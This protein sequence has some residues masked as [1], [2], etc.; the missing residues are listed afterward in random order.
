MVT[1]ACDW[2]LSSRIRTVPGEGAHT[3]S[4]LPGGFDSGR[5]IGVFLLTVEETKTERRLVAIFPFVLLSR[6]AARCSLQASSPSINIGTVNTHTVLQPR[7]NNTAITCAKKPSW[8]GR[9]SIRRCHQQQTHTHTH[10]FTCTKAYFFPAF[11]NFSIQ[12]HRSF[13]WDHFT[14]QSGSVLTFLRALLN[15]NQAFRCAGDP[16]TCTLMDLDRKKSL[17]YDSEK[18]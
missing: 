7:Y 14:K 3:G 13:A 10:E 11:P 6:G 16:Q 5:S 1:P 12:C 2:S 8:C 9:V 4:S 15:N 17:S 18:V